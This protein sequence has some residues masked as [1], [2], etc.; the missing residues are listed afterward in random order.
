VDAKGKA[1]ASASGRTSRRVVQTH[2]DESAPN[3]QPAD[4]AI[5]AKVRQ[6][7]ARRWVRTEGL[8]VGTT[9]GVVVI[10]GPLEREPGSLTMASDPDARDR[11]V[12]RLKSELRAIPGVTEVVLEVHSTE[13]GTA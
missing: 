5:N 8:E 11:F 7:L 4:F 10:K 2:G 12:W 1:R 9:D 3:G 13:R 6:L